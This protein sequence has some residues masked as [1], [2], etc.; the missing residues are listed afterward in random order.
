MS[1]EGAVSRSAAAQ[2]LRRPDGQRLQLASPG[3]GAAGRHCRGA[4]LAVDA[5]LCSTSCAGARAKALRPAV[6][7]CGA[8]LK[9]SC[10]QRPG[11]APTL[12]LGACG[13]RL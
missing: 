7:R 4:G 13:G 9:C 3:A 12:Q 6:L 10:Q 11:R 8:T 2:P 5:Q 1:G